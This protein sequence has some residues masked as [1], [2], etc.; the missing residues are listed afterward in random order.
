LPF[1]RSAFVPTDAMPG[2]VRVF[3]EN[4]PVTSIVDA[5]RDQTHSNRPA[6]TSGSTSPGASASSLSRTSSQ[7][8]CTAERSPRRCRSAG[9]ESQLVERSGE[10]SVAPAGPMTPTRPTPKRGGQDARA[11]PPDYGTPRGRQAMER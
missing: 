6:P 4:Q 11:R 8:S 1:I 9:D 5:I 2:P 3:A 7:W 10:L